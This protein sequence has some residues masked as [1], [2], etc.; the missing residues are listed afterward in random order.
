M[1]TASPSLHYTTGVSIHIYM[2][3]DRL[4]IGKIAGS[5]TTTIVTAQASYPYLLRSR[6]E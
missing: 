1:Y 6:T 5:Y 4:G 2:Y 3:I